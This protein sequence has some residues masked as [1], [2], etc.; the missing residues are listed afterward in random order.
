[1]E[2]YDVVIIGSGLGGLATAV[3]LGKEG[4]RVCLL[5]KNKQVGG[6]LQTYAREKVVFDSG[7]HYIGGLSPG[8]NTYQIFKY[9][10]I[11]EK[12]RLEKMDEDGFD[13]IIFQDDENEYPQA[14]GHENFIRQLLKF[15]PGEEEGLRAYCSKIREVCSKFPLYNLREGDF[16]SEKADILGIDTKTFIESVTENKRLREVLAGNISLY[17]GLPD[18]SP[19]YVHALV[20]NSY[21]ESAWKCVDG[22][23]QIAKYLVEEIRKHKG[24]IFRYVDVHRIV[25]TDGKI[26][27]AEAK[28]GRKFYGD[29]FI[30]N[31]HPAKTLDMLQSDLIKKA[32]RSRIKSLEN[33]ISTFTL[34]IVLKPETFPYFRHNVYYH[35]S[36][37]VWT[38]TEYT[39][40]NWPPEWALFLQPSSK[41]DVWA[42]GMTI[43]AYMRIED[44]RSW[45]HTFNTVSA[46]DERGPSYEAFKREKAERLID[47]LEIKYPH[48]R[49]CIKSYFTATPLT[50]RDYIGNEDG[51]LYGIVRD[52]K[53]PLKTFISPRTKVPNLFLTGQNL[54]LHGILGVSVSAM[55]TTMSV[56]NRN[57]LIEKVKNA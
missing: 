57:D 10:G 25:E 56:L 8:Q 46:N 37:S 4:Y 49:S 17:A 34:N 48:I 24:E 28:D 6:C 38:G 11:L 14:Q 15:F 36:D 26:E 27:Y 23:S 52:Y 54:N 55:I 44:V 1:M 42:E 31:I 33:T 5:E 50:Y 16:Y 18:K 22:G 35:D 29:I 43:L 19:F 51:A 9:L 20:I 47:K 2:K 30:S 45:E 53:N 41:S 12:L 13:R 21:I 3:F 7:V 39:E 40:K 32:Y